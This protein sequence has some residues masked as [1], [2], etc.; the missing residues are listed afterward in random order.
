MAYVLIHICGVFSTQA[1]L[2]ES[3]KWTEERAMVYSRWLLVIV[4]E[5]DVEIIGKELRTGGI[6]NVAIL[7]YDVTA[8]TNADDNLKVRERLNFID[9]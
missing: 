4:E 9:Q 7:H 3:A 6:S 2:L 1:N 5:E 8:G